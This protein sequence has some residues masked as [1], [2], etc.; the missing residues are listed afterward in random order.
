M[1][2][3]QLF[4]YS[5]IYPHAR[6]VIGEFATAVKVP[7]IASR[8]PVVLMWP[9]LLRHA[10]I[11]HGGP[12]SVGVGVQT[13]RGSMRRRRPVE[14]VRVVPVAALRAQATGLVEDR[15]SET[16]CLAVVALL[17]LR[18]DDDRPQLWALIRQEYLGGG[19]G[20]PGM[21]Y[22]RNISSFGS[23]SAP[24]TPPAAGNRRP[25]RR[26]RTSTP[27]GLLWRVF[28]GHTRF[29]QDPLGNR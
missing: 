7:R 28:S 2:L 16:G 9:T 18:R 22:L 20:E 27:R 5:V 21:A 4:Q 13:W 14:A 11:A 12:L 29:V 19:D 15:Q 1:L 23:G 26:T 25:C 6:H 10:E 3:D 8:E 17:G 24:S